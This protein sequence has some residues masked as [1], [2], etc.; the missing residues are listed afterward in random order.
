LKKQVRFAEFIDYHKDYYKD[1][2]EITGQGKPVRN[3]KGLQ[4]SVKQ[5]GAIQVFYLGASRVE[6]LSIG[7]YRLSRIFNDV[8]LS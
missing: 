5:V 8:S 4:A 6:G 2:T 1:S 7:G 3:R